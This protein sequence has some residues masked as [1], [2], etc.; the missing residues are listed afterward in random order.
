MVIKEESIY[1][2]IKGD[3]GS[4]S[5][6]PKANVDIFPWGDCKDPND[7]RPF[8]TAQLVY[9]NE[10]LY[11]R[12]E[13]AESNPRTIVKGYSNQVYTD[14]CMELFLMPDPTHS[15]RYYNWEFN[16]IGAMYLSIGTDRFDRNDMKPD[17]YISLFGVE[18]LRGD[19]KWSVQF[20][21]SHFFI[22]HDFPNYNPTAGWTMKGNFYKCGEK[23]H[24]LHYGCWANINL[25]EPDFH[26]PEFFGT[27]LFVKGNIL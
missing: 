19:D 24:R 11:I 16:S 9:D 26:S 8:T 6:A 21:I 18:T 23:T 17:D 2:I 25:P 5:C 22:K 15:N 7:Y 13:T 14:S 4:L 10:A 20:N 12:M 1:R 3:R 27:L